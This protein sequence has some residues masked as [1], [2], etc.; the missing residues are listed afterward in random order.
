MHM[1]NKFSFRNFLNIHLEKARNDYTYGENIFNGFTSI[2]VLILAYF[3]GVL[4]V[5]VIFIV[6]FYVGIFLLG[7][8]KKEYIFTV[9]TLGFVIF[10]FSIQSKDLD[11]RLKKNEQEFQDKLNSLEI[12]KLT[13]NNQFRPWVGLD[14]SEAVSVEGKIDNLK[15]DINAKFINMGS[16]PA[17][18]INIKYIHEI[19][20]KMINYTADEFDPL[21]I[22]FPDQFVKFGKGLTFENKDT[23]D[24][25]N[26]G[27]IEWKLT[28]HIRYEGVESKEYHTEYQLKYVAKL[29]RFFMLGGRV[30]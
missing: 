2:V 4:S 9:A 12:Q 21:A 24:K 30:Y 13:F 1:K 29:N 11:G 19:G 14:L 6:L 8:E 20:D 17:Q 22:L 26:D 10:S 7:N 16:V 15:L 28:I 18:N 27:T 3:L 25:I 23:F 5:G